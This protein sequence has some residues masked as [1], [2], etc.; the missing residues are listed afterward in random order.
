MDGT[1]TSSAVSEPHEKFFNTSFRIW[2]GGV[3]FRWL[4]QTN[5]DVRSMEGSRTK[6]AESGNM[7]IMRQEADMR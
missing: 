4:L 2:I 6:A 3:F 5:Q 7:S 1:G